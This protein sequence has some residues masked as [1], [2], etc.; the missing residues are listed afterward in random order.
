MS[1]VEPYGPCRLEAL[2][3]ATGYTAYRGADG[4]SYLTILACEPPVHELRVL[5]CCEGSATSPVHV[6]RATS[7]TCCYPA[8]EAPA[9]F[10]LLNRWHLEHRWPKACLRPRPSGEVEVVAD[11]EYPLGP[12][13]HDELLGELTRVSLAASLELFN[14]LAEQYRPAVPGD[15]DISELEAQFHKAG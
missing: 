8:E 15:L 9:L 12:G 3:A 14:W 7:P 13:I 6:V 4:G 1:T 11:S 2:V 5:W 10:G